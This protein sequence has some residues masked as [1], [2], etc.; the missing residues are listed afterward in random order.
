MTADGQSVARMDRPSGWRAPHPRVLWAAARARLGGMSIWAWGLVLVVAG[1]T[2]YFTRLSLDIHRGLGTSTF[3]YG[4][5]DQGVWLLSRFKAPF[6]T[7]MGRNLLGDHTSFILVLLAPLY[8]VAPGAGTLL[9]SQA[10]A[11]GLGAV[12]V[13][14]YAR[15]RLGNQA[16]ALLMAALFLLHPALQWVVLEDYHPDLYLVPLVMFAIYG[17]LTERWRMYA[18]C[19]AL[20]L[21]VK[22]DVALVMVPLGIWV[23][24]RR[25]RV[26]GLVT[27]G[28]AVAWSLFAM[29][30]VI[31]GLT[32]T[33][34]PN[35]WRIPFG[36][37][38]GL[39][40]EVLTHPGN[41]I[42]YLRGD[43]RAWY[44]WQMLSPFAWLMVRA[45]EVALISGLVLATNVISTFGYQH[46]IAYHY[47][48]V[49]LPALA[50]GTVYAVGMMKGRRRWAAVAVLAISSVWTA[51]LW[52]PLPLAR[53]PMGYWAADYP[54][55]VSAREIMGEI[56]G[57]AVVSAH[58]SLTPH[59][60]RREQI[61]SW[62]NPFSLNMYGRDISLEGRPMAEAAEVEYVVLGK[63]LTQEDAVVWDR[64][65][66]QFTLQAENPDWLLFR[67]VAA[68]DRGGLA[69]AEV[70]CRIAG[71][72][73]AGCAMLGR[74]DSGG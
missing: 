58:W 55:A 49:A 43:E 12:P 11:A 1:F 64:V 47:S 23:A 41:V 71:S 63:P 26:I 37:V 70:G 17:A 56:P 73:D 38:R 42:E 66:D 5:Y 27:I 14:L 25:D 8:W 68:D 72:A 35:A 62:P 65:S 7:L 13:F 30:V 74:V 52:G 3:D 45:P 51:Y 18:V 36:G 53:E 48:A 28:A 10:L 19:V 40:G 21:L 60:A 31:G 6:V 2:W 9:G 29:L 67:R 57:D 50:L 16:V 22:E 34:F 59:L 54:V 39:L 4:L 44:L 20:A 15:H 61:Y 24:W 32:G 69:L 33:A 46:Q